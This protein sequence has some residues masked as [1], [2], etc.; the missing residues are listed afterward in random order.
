MIHS[1]LLETLECDNGSFIQPWNGFNMKI[2]SKLCPELHFQ[3]FFKK[4]G[5]H[6]RNLENRVLKTWKMANKNL[7]SGVWKAPVTLIY[8]LQV[9]TGSTEKA[10][11]NHQKNHSIGWNY[12]FF[13]HGKV[14]GE[15]LGRFKSVFRGH[16]VHTSEILPPF[17]DDLYCFSVIIQCKLINENCFLHC[18]TSFHQSTY[19]E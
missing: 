5:K 12:Q 2:C 9:S 19:T 13:I 7:D 14:S 16:T 6:W 17:T 15:M 4:P 1:N 11:K 10:I 8:I 18:K 3:Y